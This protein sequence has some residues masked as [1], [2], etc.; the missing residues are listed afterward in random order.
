MAWEKVSDRA[1]IM[2]CGDPDIPLQTLSIRD[3]FTAS[4]SYRHYKWALMSTNVPTATPITNKPEPTMIIFI[5][6]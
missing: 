5:L 2:G 3:E 1:V 4:C 6:R